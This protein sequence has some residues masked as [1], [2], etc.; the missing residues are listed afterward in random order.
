[1]NR[2]PL[3]AALMLCIGTASAAES[4]PAPHTG[5]THDAARAE[6]AELRGQMQ[7]LS[8]RMAKLSVELGDVGPRTYALRYLGEPDRA[9]IGVVL[10]PDA[11]GAR[12]SAVTPDGPAARAGLRDGDVIV[13]IDG[14][15]V[16]GADAGTD[17]GLR[18]ARERLGDLKDGQDVRL[19]WQRG[20][21]AQ[22]DV[23]L[24]ATR[25]AAYNWQQV[26]GNAERARME[27]LDDKTRAEI[28]RAHAVARSV[29][30]ERIRASVDHA[31][32]NAELAMRRAMP[33]WGLNLVALNPDLGRYFGAERG[34]L[35][36]SADDATP[37]GLRGGDVIT[38]VAGAR[39]ADPADALRAL[40]DQPSG[41][42][43]PFKVLRDR[44]TLTLNVKAPEY[45]AI[46]SVP[47]PPE[48]PAAP[49]PPEAP[50]SP[51]APTP[52]TPPTPPAPPAD[53]DEA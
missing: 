4:V 6:L 41:K 14:K 45:K 21:K 46:F 29:D 7:E 22:R 25:R 19:S 5:D 11:K 27:A 42:E 13:A 20:G 34:A 12:I 30:A 44:K 38:E 49:L 9:L 37:S 33:W 31:M 17:A 3:L 35:V 40:R 18:A 23:V 52:P 32:R 8:S 1:M 15:P 10:A 36:V 53:A 26:V 50:P 47:T 43:V 16:S 51:T 24:K 39:V 28:E 2:T 48:P